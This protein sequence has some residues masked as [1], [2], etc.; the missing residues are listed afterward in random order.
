MQTYL[1]YLA[2]HGVTM[3]S[4]LNLIKTS[5][6]KKAIIEQAR[7]WSIYFARLFPLK[8]TSNDLHLLGVSHSGIRLIKQSRS[9]TNRSI[10]KVMDTF[11]FD[12]IQNVS[13]IRNGS[14]IEIQ[15]LKKSITVQSDRV[16]HCFQ[17]AKH[18]RFSM[19]RSTRSNK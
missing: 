18:S 14:S 19:Y 13:S 12:I 3:I 4:D 2:S 7:Q 10:L 8:T 15:L 9:A 1:L 17:Q 6:T 5:L 16:E 11:P